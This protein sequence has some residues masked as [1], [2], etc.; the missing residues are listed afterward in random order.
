MTS[1]FYLTCNI[2]HPFALDP[3]KSRLLYEKMIGSTEDEE[4]QLEYENIVYLVKILTN[5]IPTTIVHLTWVWYW[6]QTQLRRER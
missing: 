1:S 4:T 2:R 5:P 6:N 3:W